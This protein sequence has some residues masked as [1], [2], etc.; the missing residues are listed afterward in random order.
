M[1]GTGVAQGGS[2]PNRITFSV[3]TSLSLLLLLGCDRAVDEQKK[4]VDAQKEANQQ[5]VLANREA[6]E[7]ATKAQAEADKE[8]NEAQTSWL[9]MR[10]DFRHEANEDLVEIDAKVTSLEAEAKT[11]TGEKKAKINARLPALRAQREQFATDY[12]SIETASS[13]TWDAT[14]ARLK[15]QL[16]EL[17]KA[18]GDAS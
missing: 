12:K 9:K 14:K 8:I 17:E 3:F 10:E 15:K 6:T 18:V 5:I 7:K 16:D 1:F 4:A 13:T 11:A 2:M